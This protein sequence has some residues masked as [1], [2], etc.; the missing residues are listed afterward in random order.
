MSSRRFHQ[1]STLN[2]PPAF[3]Q[4]LEE[5]PQPGKSGHSSLAKC[6]CPWRC[7]CSARPPSASSLPNPVLNSRPRLP[8]GPL[9]APPSR[10]QDTVPSGGFLPA[11][12]ISLSSSLF[13]PSPQP[14]TAGGPGLSSH[15]SNLPAVTPH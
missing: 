3:I 2:Y 5:Q 4:A 14:L 7:G 12:F 6:S 8:G 1:T 9:M 11:S 13:L 10:L 15:P